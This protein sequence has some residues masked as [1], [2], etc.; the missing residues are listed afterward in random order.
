MYSLIRKP[1]LFLPLVLFLGVATFSYGEAPRVNVNENEVAAV[2]V[3]FGPSYRHHYRRGYRQPY[4]R[5]YNYRHYNYRP[6]YHNYPYNQ[7][8]P[9]YWHHRG[10]GFNFRIR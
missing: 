2:R 5:H 1:L 7:H 9:Y 8:R 6:Y 3:Y 10:G 4:Y